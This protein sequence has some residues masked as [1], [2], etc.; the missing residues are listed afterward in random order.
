MP[1]RPRL[2]SRH[3]P[4]KAFPVGGRGAGLAQIAV[5]D[6]DLIDGPAERDRALTQ[7]VLPLRAL[8]VLEDLP[9][10]RLADVEI[11]RAPQMARRDFLGDMR[12]RH[13]GTSEDRTLSAICVHTCSR[14][15]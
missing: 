8:G 3:E 6:D 12:T 15:A 9:E 2:T 4:L 7:G 13:D 10:R 5:D 1:A 14:S 11:R